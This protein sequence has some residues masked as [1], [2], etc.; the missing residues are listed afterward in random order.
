VSGYDH[1]VTLNG[2]IPGSTYHLK[3]SATNNSGFTTTGTDVT[4]TLPAFSVSFIADQGNVGVYAIEGNFDAQSTDGSIN[5]AARQAVAKEYFK[6]H[7]DTDFLVFFSTFDY[8]MPGP[9]AKGFYLEVKND[10]Q[11]IN[12]A[13]LDTS[14]Q[15]GSPG[16]LQGTIDMGNTSPLAA[17]LTG[18]KRDE[19][20]LT[21]IHEL[22]HRW[23]A[24]VRFKQA[25]GSLSND[26]I[27]KDNSH[28]SYLL[29]SK[30]SL[31]YGNG[32]RDNA[33][34]TFTAVSPQSGF[35]PLDLYLMGMLPK[36]QV[37][38]MLL[39]DN[40]AIDKTKLPELGVTITGTAK[41]VTIADIIAAEGAR[42]PN[43][44]TSQK[45]FNIGFVLLTRTGDDTIAAV[46]TV[47]TVRNAFAGK[48]AELTQGI[49]GIEGV[50]PS[51]TVTIDTPASG[52][53]ITGPYTTVSGSFINTSGA[54]TGVTVNGIPATVSANRFIANNIPLQLGDNTLTIIATDANGLTTTTTRTVTAQAGNYIQITSNIESGVGPL[55][56][57]LWL[58]GSFTI[59]NPAI[60]ATGPVTPQIAAGSTAGEYTAKFLVEGTYTI[61]AS[62]VGPDGLTY[63]DTVTIIVQN[64]EKID[65][66]LRTKWNSVNTYLSSGNITKALSFFTASSKERYSAIFNQLASIM[67]NILTTFTEFKTIEIGDGIARYK[68]IVNEDGKLYA[69]DI[70]FLR[71]ENNGLWLLNSY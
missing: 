12:R 49:G 46:Q 51:L 24:A 71:D 59:I 8:A 36:E 66:L 35:S 16:M 69:Y 44:A 23:L 56:V 42:V 32:W 61:A 57:S 47:E 10:T 5:T 11:G 17:D 38:A 67:P 70:E 34:G 27:G 60:S 22:G 64:Q 18:P 26:L 54:E 52:A 31:M 3:I 30:G 7:P 50:A 2:L 53:T 6:T 28:W 21:L 15:Y 40:S 63:T 33:N 25:D 43:A 14:A 41:T 65:N 68:L 19:T 29:D 37:P 4:V 55:D 20:V 1:A 48:F 13:I 45:R 62:A 9:T 58:N 39:I